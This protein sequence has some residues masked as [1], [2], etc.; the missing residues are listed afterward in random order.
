MR[1][2]LA[3]KTIRKLDVPVKGQADYFDK[4]TPGF[5]LRVSAT[6]A[7][8]WIVLYRRNGRKQ[9]VTLGPEDA[10]SLAEARA[11][12]KDLLARVR[13]GEDP[14]AEKKANRE[15]PT[16]GELV[17]EYLR[18]HAAKKRSGK[19]DEQM[20]KRHVPKSWANT[21][22]RDITRRQVRD[23]LDSLV[24]D[25][26]PIAANRLL[27]CLRKVFNF[28]IDREI[29]EANPC[30]RIARPAPENQRDRVLSAD[31][32]RRLWAALDTTEE[33]QQA[34]AI[35]K[36]MLWT[37]QRGGE[38]KAME[39]TE[40]DLDGWWTIPAEK[41][42]NGLTHRAPLSPPAVRFLRELRERANGSPYVFPSDG[43]RG[44]RET[45][46]KAVAD[47]RTASGVSFVPHDL[48][49]TVATY[50][51]GELNVPRLVVSK[52][53]NH[54]EPGVTKVYDRASYDGEK[55]C[56]LDS[57]ARRLHAIVTAKPATKVVSLKAS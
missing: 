22:A 19:A 47:L 28:G 45:I 42:K 39:W 21:L 54:V 16:W 9:R 32:L 37:A 6:G 25:G 38:A 15:A 46:A 31:E 33:H 30:A 55:R 35:L 5:G 53:L 12:A 44:H 29:V 27:A 34:A 48:R 24:Q 20:L 50:L 49:R 36:L 2:T 10:L 26:K 17:A 52:L 8:S 57:W 14:A 40:V 13:L 41:A 43:E 18:L 51:T 3:D 11:R 23:L 56:A 1:V 4:T 7:R